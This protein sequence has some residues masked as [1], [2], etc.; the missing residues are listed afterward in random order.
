MPYLVVRVVHIRLKLPPLRVLVADERGPDD[1]QRD[2]V[3]GSLAPGNAVVLL[4][5][6]SN[7]VSLSLTRTTLGQTGLQ[8]NGRYKTSVKQ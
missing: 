3:E 8:L 1:G 2:V 7:S 6:A 5:I 4:F